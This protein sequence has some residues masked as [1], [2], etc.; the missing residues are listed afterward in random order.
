MTLGTVHEISTRK[1]KRMQSLREKIHCLLRWSEKYTKADMVYFA[2]GNFW[3]I[4]GRFIG[5]GSGVALTIVF[6]N[7][8][9]KEIF[10]TYKYIISLAGFL[11]AFSLTG[12]GTAVARAVAQGFDGI[13]RKAFYVSMK[14]S[15]LGSIVAASGAFYYFLQGNPTLGFSLSC[16]A[17]LSPFINSGGISKGFFLGKKE[18]KKPALYGIPRNI[19]AVTAII[20][21]V[22]VTNNVVALIVVYFL[23]NAV[24]SLGMYWYALRLY[25]P[26]TME[27]NTVVN[28]TFH[29]AK[30]LSVVGFFT[31]AVSELDKLLLWHFTGPAQLATYTFATAPVRELRNI[32]E[33]IFP[34]AFP[35]FAGKPINEIKKTIVFRMTQM[36]FVTLPIAALYILMAPYLFKLVFPQYLDAVLYSQIFVLV[37]LLQPRGF[38]GTVISSHAKVEETYIMTLSDSLVR[39]LLLFILLPLYGVLGAIIALLL[40]EF[41]HT[42]ILLILFKKI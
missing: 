32:T 19:I 29:Y 4:A 13:L 18:F 31:Q 25:R 23:V 16:I 22:L 20:I 35:K 7:L 28:E 42:I 34:L 27:E 9:P 5:I 1:N 6:A 39:A 40:A 11:T 3:M 38:I 33:N 24:L 2:S 12:M 26:K 41:I 30:H 8:L 17:A 15:L 10:G 14:W 37:L 36:F 21:T